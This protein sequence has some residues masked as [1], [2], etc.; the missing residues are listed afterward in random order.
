MRVCLSCEHTLSPRPAFELPYLCA[1]ARLC[2]RGG[3]GLRVAPALL[4]CALQRLSV[5]QSFGAALRTLHV[6]RAL[7]HAHTCAWHGGIV[8]KKKKDK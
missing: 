6:Q 1:R 8:N 5:Q 2:L 7:L 3:L 4:T